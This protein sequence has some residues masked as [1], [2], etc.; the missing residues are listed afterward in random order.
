M[1]RN[2]LVNHHNRRQYLVQELQRHHDMIR[3]HLVNHHNR[4]HCLVQELQRHHDLIRNRNH[5]HNSASYVQ[6]L[7]KIMNMTKRGKKK[8]FSVTFI[9]HSF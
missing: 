4:R 2:R 3:N 7:N 6:D 5:N 8:L 1:I 9:M